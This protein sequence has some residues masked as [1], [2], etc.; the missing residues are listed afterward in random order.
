MYGIDSSILR[1]VIPFLNG[2][3]SSCSN[4]TIIPSPDQLRHARSNYVYYYKIRKGGAFLFPILHT[5][6]W[7]T[8]YRKWKG[9]H[10]DCEQK[11][12]QSKFPQKVRLSYKETC[13]VRMPEHTKWDKVLR[14]V[15]INTQ[16]LWDFTPHN[17]VD[18]KTED[19]GKFLWN[20][21]YQTTWPHIQEDHNLHTE[22][23]DN[24]KSQ[25]NSL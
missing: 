15:N 24:L 25:I 17:T 20:L 1:P 11:R 21:I 8:S 9:F 19:K 5:P 12:S 10:M 16:V 4:P 7:I 13:L 2:S 3:A 6:R 22:G 18:T 14:A 23:C